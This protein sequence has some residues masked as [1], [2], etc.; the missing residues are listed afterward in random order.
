MVYFGQPYLPGLTPELAA[1]LTTGLLAIS[2]VFLRAGS[3][4]DAVKAVEEIKGYLE[5][6]VAG[7]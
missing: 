1:E 5:T 3:K 6:P 4:T 2:L 7:E